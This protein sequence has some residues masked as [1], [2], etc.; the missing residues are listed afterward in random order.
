[1][2]DEPRARPEDV[3]VQQLLQREAGADAAIWG[4]SIRG[5]RVRLSTGVASSACGSSGACSG[6]AAQPPQHSLESARSCVVASAVRGVSAACGGMVLLAGSAGAVCRSAAADRA[7][8]LLVKVAPPWAR[9]RVLPRYGP[10]GRSVA[11]QPCSCESAGGQRAGL[12]AVPRWG[13]LFGGWLRGCTR[14]VCLDDVD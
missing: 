8:P 6:P 11:C 9:A 14:T 3:V 5:L 4:V 10:A 2:R 13:R 1:M 7:G 12:R